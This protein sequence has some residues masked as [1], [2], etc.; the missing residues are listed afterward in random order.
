VR[1][2]NRQNRKRRILAVL[3]TVCGGIA[4]AGLMF[5][6]YGDS[7]PGV[8]YGVPAKVTVLSDPGADRKISIYGKEDEYI[9]ADL[10]GTAY[11]IS[12]NGGEG[13]DLSAGNAT[14]GTVRDVGLIY[15]IPVSDTKKGERSQISIELNKSAKAESDYKFLVTQLRVFLELK[16]RG[17]SDAS[18]A[19]AA[20]AFSVENAELSAGQIS[21][22][23]DILIDLAGSELPLLREGMNIETFRAS[24]DPAAAAILW[25]Q[26]SQKQPSEAE[27]LSLTSSAVQFYEDWKGYGGEGFD[28][29]EEGLQ[30]TG[31]P[32]V[33]GGNNLYSGID[34]SHYVWQILLR[35]GYYDGAYTDSA[36]FRELGR[37]VSYEELRPGDVLCWK[38]HVGF[39]LGGS[40]ILNAASPEMG[41]CVMDVDIRNLLGG[42]LTIRRFD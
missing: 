6:A 1:K 15:G 24:E 25:Y 8:I 37:E 35:T 4:L 18:A 30:Y 22:K 7:D 26:S 41:I 12:G 38:G 34:C 33:Y 40:Y 23:L 21:D 32:Y 39:Y 5:T 9:M 36:G 3:L 10:G 42:L 27:R 31:Y 13:L 11:G 14:P 20:A 17:F 28:I 19:G 29:I 2:K 16:K